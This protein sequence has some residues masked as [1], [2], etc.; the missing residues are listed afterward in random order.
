M[1]KRLIF[2]SLIFMSIQGFSQEKLNK[3]SVN[4]I[5]LFGFNITN[6]EYERGFIDGKLGV[7]FYYGMTGMASRSIGGYSV[8]IAEQNISIKGYSR[9][10]DNNSFWYGGQLSVASGSI[11]G[12]NGSATNVGTLGLSG[13][14]GYQLIIKS[15]YLDFYGGLG[16]ALTNNLFGDVSYSGGVSE[17]KLLLIY[18]IKTGIAF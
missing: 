8:Y 7:S 17:T 12:D 5:Q 1:R 13:K 9:S 3:L 6:F 11:W 10:I 15:F 2:L 18:G 16:Y 14:L 4:P